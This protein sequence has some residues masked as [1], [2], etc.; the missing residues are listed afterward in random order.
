MEGVQLSDNTSILQSMYSKQ[1]PPCKRV[2]KKWKSFY[3]PAFVYKPLSEDHGRENLQYLTMKFRDTGYSNFKKLAGHVPYLI[4]S[5]SV[6]RTISY[7]L[8]KNG[9]IGSRV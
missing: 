2:Y 9:I 7:Y 5:S 4:K 8:R 3:R 1:W 6:L